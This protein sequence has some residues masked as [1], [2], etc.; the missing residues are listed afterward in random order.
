MALELMLVSLLEALANSSR[1]NYPG[2]PSMFGYDYGEMPQY[3][4][5]NFG[6]NPC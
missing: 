4:T 3:L 6:W 1:Y 5:G 2:I